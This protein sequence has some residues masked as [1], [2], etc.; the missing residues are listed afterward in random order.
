MTH[1]DVELD[2]ESADQ[3]PRNTLRKRLHFNDITFPE[4]VQEK[5]ITPFLTYR[6]VM[7]TQRTQ[8]MIPRDIRRMVVHLMSDG[9]RLQFARDRVLDPRERNGVRLR[10]DEVVHGD[11]REKPLLRLRLSPSQ[12]GPDRRRCRLEQPVE[13]AKT[14]EMSLDRRT[15]APLKA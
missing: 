13:A 3:M 11:G 9:S 7:K 10:T 8:D 4:R 5:P 15:Q 12:I 2:G 1:I 14:A 6:N